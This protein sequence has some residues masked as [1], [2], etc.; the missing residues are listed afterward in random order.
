MNRHPGPE[1]VP[2]VLVTLGLLLSGCTDRESVD[3]NEV[4]WRG[5]RPCRRRSS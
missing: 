5:A 3:G 1:V 4:G 2:A